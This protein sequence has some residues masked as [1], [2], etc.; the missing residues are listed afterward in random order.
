MDDLP[1][2]IYQSYWYDANE[3]IKSFIRNKYLIDKYGNNDEEHIHY[4]CITEYTNNIDSIQRKFINLNPLID[5]IVIFSINDI[6][7]KFN[8]LI[9]K[10][11]KIKDRF[12]VLLIYCFD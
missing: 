6:P 2:L 10:N 8:N 4:M 3:E 1:F 5:E 7:E 9:P 12:Y 11:I